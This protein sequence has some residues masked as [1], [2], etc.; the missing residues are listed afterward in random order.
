LFSKEVKKTQQISPSINV[1]LFKFISAVIYENN[2]RLG[3]DRNKNWESA[4]I[5]F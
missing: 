2:C 4:T 1:L 3:V 5:G